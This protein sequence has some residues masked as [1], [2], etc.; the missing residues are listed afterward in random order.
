[1]FIPSPDLFSIGGALA[2]TTKRNE[3]FQVPCVHHLFFS[4][5]VNQLSWNVT[6]NWKSGNV[7]LVLLAFVERISKNPTS[8][9]PHPCPVFTACHPSS[10][11]VALLPPKLL[12]IPLDWWPEYSCIQ[13]DPFTQHWLSRNNWFICKDFPVPGYTVTP[14]LERIPA[15]LAWGS[16]LWCT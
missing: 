9:H 7:W 11:R 6:T 4:S 8:G 12:T 5:L 16:M 13:T 1:M 2:R 3:H 15:E 10:S 14:N